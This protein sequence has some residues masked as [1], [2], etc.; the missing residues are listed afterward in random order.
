MLSFEFFTH[1]FFHCD[2]NSIPVHVQCFNLYTLQIIEVEMM[3][4][5]K[6]IVCKIFDK[7]RWRLY[8]KNLKHHF[9]FIQLHW[10]K[11]FWYSKFLNKVT[12]HT[13]HYF[14]LMLRKCWKREDLAYIFRKFN[15][16]FLFMRHKIDY[17]YWNYRIRFK[18]NLRCSLNISERNLERNEKRKQGL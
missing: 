4:S 14:C 5:V 13:T 10:T 16:F 12:L 17:V 11:M 18:G 6:V 8:D 7:T 3:L 9:L 1:F 2:F 15:M